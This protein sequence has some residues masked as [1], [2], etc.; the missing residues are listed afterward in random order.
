MIGIVDYGMGNL[1]SV[2][3]ALATSGF[4]SQW[5]RQPSDLEACDRIVLPGVGAF[6]RAMANLRRS[7]LIAPLRDAIDK[8]RPFLGICLGEPRRAREQVATFYKGW[9]DMIAAA[10]KAGR[11]MAL[12]QDLSSAYALGSSSC[13]IRVSSMACT[14]VLAWSLA[15]FGNCQRLSECLMSGGI[16][17]ASLAKAA[18]S[19]A[20]QTRRTSTSFSPTT[21]IR[22]IR[23]SSQEQQTMELVLLLPSNR[24]T[25]S[26][27]SFIR[28]RVSGQDFSCS[29]IS[30]GYDVDHS[31]Y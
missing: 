20:Y 15:T 14:R 22:P 11:S 3:K 24:A 28:R 13:L 29:Q 9:F 4:D 12:F 8:E 6:G 27:C 25:C 5:I 23:L 10:P 18:C 2:R 31:R 26:V 1:E 17:W 7:G 16:Q 21:L 19:R 30:G